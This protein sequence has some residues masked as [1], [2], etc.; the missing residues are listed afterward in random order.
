MAYRHD[1]PTLVAAKRRPAGRG[2]G[3][4][5][6]RWILAAPPQDTP[7]GLQLWNVFVKRAL[8]WLAKRCGPARVAAI[9]NSSR[10]R[11]RE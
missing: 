10:K 6:P 9:L 11:K 2:P 7:S 5:P 4:P 1:Y 3:T 8:I